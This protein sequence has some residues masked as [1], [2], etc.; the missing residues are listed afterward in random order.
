MKLTLQEIKRILHS[1]EI[2]LE[3]IQIVA[4]KLFESRQKE[5][6]DFKIENLSKEILDEYK[7]KLSEPLTNDS[8]EDATSKTINKLLQ[9]FS[10][11]K[12]N[13]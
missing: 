8:V 7:S 5:K 12:N 2:N 9:L 6:V 11:V 10:N 4:N 13:N 1:K 3:L